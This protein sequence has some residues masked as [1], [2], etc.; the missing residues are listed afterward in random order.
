MTKKSILLLSA[1]L[2]LSACTRLN[3]DVDLT[4][5][6]RQQYERTVAEFE[7]KIKNYQPDDRF[8]TPEAPIPF[9]VE[10]AVAQEN[11]GRLDD[12]LRTYTKA[13]KIYPRSQAIENNIG[14][15]YEKAG[16]REKAIEQ[17]LYVADEFQD[18]RYYRDITKLYI[19]L[20]DRR[21]AEKYFN[22]WQLAT[23]QTDTEIQQEIKQLREEEKAGS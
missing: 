22:V 19:E 4:D 10:L 20:K 13:Q 2:L 1:L 11:L 17:Y 6:Q 15:L 7:F 21:N 23:R 16:L 12:A 8:E 14:R 18:P 5:E 3:I 9:W